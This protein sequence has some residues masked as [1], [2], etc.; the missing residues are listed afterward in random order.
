M[1]EVKDFYTLGSDCLW[2][3][4]ADGSLWWA[5]AWPEVT[6]LERTEGPYASRTP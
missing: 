3:T 4:F 6:M 2:I 5:F 1:R